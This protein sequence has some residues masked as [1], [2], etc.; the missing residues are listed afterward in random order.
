MREPAALLD[1]LEVNDGQGRASP[2]SGGVDSRK[3][4]FFLIVGV[5][6]N[7]AGLHTKEGYSGVLS[8]RD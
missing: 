3:E 4:G 8:E 5:A 7:G 1:L 6:D 2:L